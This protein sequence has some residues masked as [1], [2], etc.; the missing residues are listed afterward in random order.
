MLLIFILLKFNETTMI[1][2]LDKANVSQVFPQKRLDNELN[3]YANDKFP[4]QRTGANIFKLQT[5]SHN[6]WTCE[7]IVT[8]YG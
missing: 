4:K 7:E 8:I 5:F 3:T 2:P 6:Y 1:I